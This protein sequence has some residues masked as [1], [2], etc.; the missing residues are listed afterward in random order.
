LIDSSFVID[1]ER[2][3]GSVAELRER[4][5]GD[6]MAIA[7]ITLSELL[8]GIHRASD[9]ARQARRQ[10]SLHRLVALVR[11]LPF[12]EEVARRHAAIAAELTAIGEPI[13]AHDLIIAATAIVHG[14]TLITLDLRHF[15]RVPGLALLTTPSA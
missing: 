8:V 12:D 7:T 13:G 11:V 15:P 2:R 1:L 4:I 10:E 3:R 6:R 9:Q 14:L 5:G